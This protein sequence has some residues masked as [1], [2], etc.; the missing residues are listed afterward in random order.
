MKHRYL[1]VVTCLLAGVAS[2][3]PFEKDLSL[4][5]ITFHV[6]S[7]NEGSKNPVEITV[8]GLKGGDKTLN[9]EADGLVTGA[10]VADLNSDG[11]PEIYIFTQSVGSGSYGNIIAWSSNRNLSATEIHLSEMS[12]KDSMGF[13]GHDEFAIVEQYLVRRFPVYKAGDTNAKATGGIRQIQYRLTK[14][15]ASW[16]L[17]PVKTV[18]FD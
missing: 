7:K 12:R 17:R 4:Q 2:A 18:N 15:E 1:T 16:Q 6:K 3:A 8:R 13:M 10:E 14:G 5:G 11:S 9:S